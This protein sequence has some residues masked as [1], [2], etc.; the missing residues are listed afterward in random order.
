MRRVLAPSLL[1]LIV[2]WASVA[3]PAQSLAPSALRILVVVDSSSSVGPVLNPIRAALQTLFTE[4]PPDSEVVMVSTGGQ[5]R[6]R[7]TPTRDRER[8]LAQAKSFAQ[9]GGANAL[10]DT[11]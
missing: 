5:L 1:L 7:M 10:V 9:D 4:I 3:V 8:W 6:V 2:A 11:L